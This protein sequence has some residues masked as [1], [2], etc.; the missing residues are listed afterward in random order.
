MGGFEIVSLIE[1]EDLTFVE[2]FEQKFKYYEK[3]SF[4][5]LLQ[6]YKF[7]IWIYS[8]ISSNN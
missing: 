4:S 7:K 2:E 6:D 1:I 8:F 3:Q 5:L